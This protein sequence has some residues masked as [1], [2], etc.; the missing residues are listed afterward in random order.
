MGSSDA[1]SKANKLT[2]SPEPKPEASGQ[3]LSP[4]E[5][6]KTIEM[7]G[8]PEQK[9]SATISDA[10]ETAM[11]TLST[12]AIAGVPLQQA[13]EEGLVQTCSPKAE[14]GDDEFPSGGDVQE[15]IA[16]CMR[17]PNEGK[18][19]LT[20]GF[21]IKERAAFTL[22]LKRHGEHP[23]AMG[24]R[25]TREAKM[26]ALWQHLQAI[27]NVGSTGIRKETCSKQEVMASWLTAHELQ[28]RFGPEAA[29][30]LMESPLVLHRDHSQAPGIMQ[31]RLLDDMFSS[32]S[33]REE[34]YSL[35]SEQALS[36]GDAAAARG[37]LQSESEAT[38]PLPD[39]GECPSIVILPK[40]ERGLTCSAKAKQG[41]KAKRE[42]PEPAAK[43][44]KTA[45][46][47]KVVAA[48]MYDLL[49]KLIQKK[50]PKG[51]LEDMVLPRWTGF[52]ELAAAEEVSDAS[53]AS[54]KLIQGEL[55]DLLGKK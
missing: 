2:M 32:S 35:A 16:W 13:A 20:T 52:K 33:S 40:G 31:Y 5:E 11:Q 48:K 42:R 29:A 1:A 47:N 54:L 22:K 38:C 50:D 8:A 37:W 14:M 4:N 26:D 45:P 49:Y 3:T 18:D 28:R 23:E 17:Q 44:G 30:K 25:V 24:R 51:P 12:G 21:T 36:S 9:A 39:V 10:A 55:H 34:T 41:P 43:R 15:R 6:L 19:F 27:H 46:T 53:L 7:L